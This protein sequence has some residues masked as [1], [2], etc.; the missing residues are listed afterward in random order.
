ML[1]PGHCL[2]DAG[3]RLGLVGIPARV[4]IEVQRYPGGMT[5][6][7]PGDILSSFAAATTKFCHIPSVARDTSNSR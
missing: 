5:G 3:S 7:R 4:S 2:K 6:D 1:V